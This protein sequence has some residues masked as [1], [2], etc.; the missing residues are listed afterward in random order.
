MSDPKESAPPI[1]EPYYA[2]SYQQGSN[3]AAVAPALGPTTND[4]GLAQRLQQEE[5]RNALPTARGMP[6]QPGAPGTQYVA[7]FPPS[8]PFDPADLGVAG[9][10]A[11]HEAKL[12][13]A[14]SLAKTIRLLAV[15]DGLILVINCGYFPVLLLLLLWG[16]LS[17]WMAGTK[18]STAWTYA[19]CCYYLLRLSTYLS[20]VFEG[21]I[22]F[23]FLF[24]LSLYI[25]RVIWRFAKVLDT[26]SPAEIEQLRNPTAVWSGQYHRQHQQQ[27]QPF[28]SL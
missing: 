2:S 21:Y 7:I 18:Y 6:V 4:E 8:V 11:P 27:Q 24:A 1:E 13:E 5:F 12:V 23:I 9:S 22:W 16:P 25:A 19:Y 10:M 14:S 3:A 28:Q 17:G 26:L 20:Y 15:L